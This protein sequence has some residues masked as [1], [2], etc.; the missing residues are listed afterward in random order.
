MPLSR[1]KFLASLIAIPAGL[2]AAVKAASNKT[3]KFVWFVDWKD[4]EFP[5][6]DTPIVRP[7]DYNDLSNQRVWTCYNAEYEAALDK[8]MSGKSKEEIDAWFG[9]FKA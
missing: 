5:K 6:K 2:V 7:G 1:R 8:I 3:N 4:I 9:K